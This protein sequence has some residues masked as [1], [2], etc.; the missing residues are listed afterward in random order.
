MSDKAHPYVPNGQGQ[1]TYRIADLS[2]P[3]LKPWVI[4][5]MRKANEEVLTGESSFYRERAV[6]AGRR[7]RVEYLQLGPTYSFHSN[8]QKGTYNKRA[9]RSDTPYLF[10]RAPFGTCDAVVVWRIRW[11]S[12][13]VPLPGTAG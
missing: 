6:L 4:E 1:P 7:S 12:E 5:R 10:E 9:P 11:V 8:T 13:V 3:I 2:N